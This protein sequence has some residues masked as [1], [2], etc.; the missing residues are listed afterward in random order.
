MF[1]GVIEELGTVRSLSR[2]GKGYT[3]TI[4]SSKLIAGSKQGDSIS[5]N[6]VCL[7]ITNADARTLS[8]DVLDK[9]L[10]RA[11]LQQLRSGDRVN[12]ERA[13]MVGDRISGHFVTGHIDCQGR[14]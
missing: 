14:I 11:N 7:T 13:L 8:F 1:S 12:L 6:G 3:L 9:T 5:V 2:Q 10:S 4:E